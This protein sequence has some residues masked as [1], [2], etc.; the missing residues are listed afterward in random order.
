MRRAAPLIAGLVILL[1][2]LI[3]PLMAVAAPPPQDSENVRITRPVENAV[4]SGVVTITGTALDPAFRFYH[5]EYAIDPVTSASLWVPAQAPVNQ[6]V[7]DGVLG[8]WDTTRVADGRYL[9]RLRVERADGTSVED[10]VRVR[11]ANATPTPRFVATQTP[12][13][14][15]GAGPLIEQPPTRTPRPTLTPGGPTLTPGAP[16]A[17]EGPF[18]REAIRAAFWQGVRLTLGAFALIGAY[19]LLRAALRG[20]LRRWWWSFRRETINPLLDSIRRRGSKR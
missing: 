11:V 10:T 9:L 14:G 15:G 4:L 5:L 13:A 7:R 1:A 17:D 20:Q 2:G 16:G 12:G 18:G 19:G 6:Q 8:S 3:A